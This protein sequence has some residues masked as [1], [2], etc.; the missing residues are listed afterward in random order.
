MIPGRVVINEADV[1]SAGSN[2]FTISIRT[3]GKG[4]A[5]V[6]LDTNIGF[7]AVRD[8]YAKGDVGRIDLTVRFDSTVAASASKLAV[9]CLQAAATKY[10]F[11]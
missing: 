7:P 3:D 11:P 5:L 4:P 9:V 1:L 8:L 6:T 2:Q 10:D